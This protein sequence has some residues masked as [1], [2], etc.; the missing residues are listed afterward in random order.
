MTSESKKLQKKRLAILAEMDELALKR[1][2]SCR[3]S[4]KYKPIEL[5]CCEA[6]KRIRSLGDE[7]L[8][9]KGRELKPLKDEIE[10]VHKNSKRIDHS[11]YRVIAE[12]NGIIY[13]TYISRVNNGIPMDVAATYTTEGLREWRERHDK[14]SGTGG[15][16]H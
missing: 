5:E 9:L 6:A 16:T 2:P 10:I 1:C 12:Q 13:S 8:R 7:L 15:E 14:Q 11:K 3:P 4:G